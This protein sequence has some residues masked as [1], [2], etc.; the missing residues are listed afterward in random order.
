MKPFSSCRSINRHSSVTAQH[1]R[2]ISV[3]EKEAREDPTAGTGPPPVEADAGED[4]SAEDTKT[5]VVGIKRTND[6]ASLERETA[7]PVS[8]L[9]TPPFSR[10]FNVDVFSSVIDEPIRDI[11]SRHWG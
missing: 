5:S 8:A 4:T 3:A 1:V 2:T 11:G 10:V 6:S 9:S 7:S